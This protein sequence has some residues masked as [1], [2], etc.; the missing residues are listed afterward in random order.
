[1]EQEFIAFVNSAHMIPNQKQRWLEYYM[2][3]GYIKP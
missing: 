1:M 2:Q 3:L